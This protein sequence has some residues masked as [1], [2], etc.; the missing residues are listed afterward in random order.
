MAVDSYWLRKQPEYAPSPGT[1]GICN[2]CVM[3]SRTLPGG[4]CVHIDAC[5]SDGESV[6]FMTRADFAA[7]RLTGEIPMYRVNRGEP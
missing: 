7:W 2:K 3:F 5:V 6:V 4:R 1:G